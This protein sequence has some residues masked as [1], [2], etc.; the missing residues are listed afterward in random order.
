M[1]MF[2][3]FLM[4]MKH[5]LLPR[6]IRFALR[7]V[8]QPVIIE[9]GANDGHTGDPLHR[10]ILS[11]PDATAILVEPVP[12]LFRKLEA[13]YAGVPQCRLENVAI[14]GSTGVSPIYFIDSS[15]RSELPSLPDYFEELASF[16]RARLA[17]LVQSRPEYLREQ[18]VA[19]TPL[20]LLIEKYSL[21]HVHLLQVDTEGYDYEVLKTFPFAR[22][23]P[24]IVCFEHCHLCAED[25]AAAFN[26]L[27]KVGYKIERGGKDAVAIRR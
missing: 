1:R 27:R 11:R 17:P 10:Y 25:R 20:H 8:S 16:D 12:H 7:H 21:Q 2:K 23:R 14:A 19:T 26:L 24:E 22:I 18:M 5:V 15:A 4:R 9:V 6:R 13:T 3:P